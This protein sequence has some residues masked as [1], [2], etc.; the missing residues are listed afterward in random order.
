MDSDI[1]K[2][3]IPIKKVQSETLTTQPSHHKTIRHKK[4]KALFISII[5]VVIAGGG[6]LYLLESQPS[7]V[8]KFADNVLRP[9]LGNK[10]TIILE[11]SS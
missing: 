10:N 1:T 9:T 11:N 6:S 4:L 8:A 7:F 3:N 2:K 5:L